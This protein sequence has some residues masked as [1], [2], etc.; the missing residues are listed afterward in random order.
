VGPPCGVMRPDAPPRRAAR[1]AVVPDDRRYPV[2]APYQRL[3]QQRLLQRLA[4]DAAGTM[5]PREGGEVAGPDETDARGVHFVQ[6]LAGLRA[7][8][9]RSTYLSWTRPSENTLIRRATNGVMRLIRPWPR[10]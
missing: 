10:R 1:L 2:A 4:I 7:I 8:S 6:A 9:V 5:L 3:R